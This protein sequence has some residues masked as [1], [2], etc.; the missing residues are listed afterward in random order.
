MD[1]FYRNS[2][3]LISYCNFQMLHKKQQSSID[4]RVQMKAKTNGYNTEQ[5]CQLMDE[6]KKAHQKMFKN[7]RQIEENMVSLG[8]RP[9]HWRR[10]FGNYREGS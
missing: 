4:D 7:N 6:F 9:I 2:V 5:H 1:Q 3:Y 8:A 10:N